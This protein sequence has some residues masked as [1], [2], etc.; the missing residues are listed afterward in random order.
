ME[1]GFWLEPDAELV[2][3]KQKQAQT[4]AVVQLLHILELPQLELDEVPLLPATIASWTPDVRVKNSTT[5]ICFPFTM[6]LI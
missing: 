3:L 6:V 2:L 4:L 1:T 5:S